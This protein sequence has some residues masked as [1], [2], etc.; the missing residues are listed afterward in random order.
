[1]GPVILKST[2]NALQEIVAKEYSHRQSFYAAR[3]LPH[4]HLAPDKINKHQYGTDPVF[5]VDS[6][7]QA[8]DQK[9]IQQIPQVKL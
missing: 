9:Y 3:F 7:R 8:K 1:M 4:Q 5:I 2:Q 6:I